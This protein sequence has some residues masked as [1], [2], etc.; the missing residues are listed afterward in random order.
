M[1]HEIV[2]EKMNLNKNLEVGFS[3][4]Y[5]EKKVVDIT[6]IG[7]VKKKM[8]EM[9]SQA[10]VVI[11]GVSDENKNVK[12]VICTPENDIT[13]SENSAKINEENSKN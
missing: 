11:N 9:S 13:L 10:D 8:R 3:Q 6:K 4:N 7:V 5:D 1:C 12:Y 2:Q